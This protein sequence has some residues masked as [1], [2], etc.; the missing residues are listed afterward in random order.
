MGWWG[1]HKDYNSKLEAVID[2]GGFKAE[3][4]VASNTDSDGVYLA[5][6]CDNNEIIGVV[7]LVR[8]QD[9]ATMVKTMDET[10][11]PYYYGASRKVLDVLTPTTSTEAQTWR[12]KCRAALVRKGE[13]REKTKALKVG[14]EY[15]V[16]RPI[17]LTSGRT[18]E[19]GKTV[20]VLEV[21]RTNAVFEADGWFRFKLRVKDMDNYIT[22]ATPPP[23]VAPLVLVPEPT[24]APS[25]PAPVE[26]PAVDPYE[27][28]LAAAKRRRRA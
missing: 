10:M 16:T 20:R 6:R 14:S 27:A 4:I 21:G 7:C 9:G 23:E 28:I 22:S 18:I 5:Y 17:K 26:A 15:R 19:E 12:D 25:E 11:G 3:R 13:I 2:N 1:T 8:R 24:P